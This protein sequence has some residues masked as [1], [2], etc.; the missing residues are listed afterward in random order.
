MNLYCNFVIFSKSVKKYWPEK[1]RAAKFGPLTVRCVEEDKS[2]PDV[3]IRV[4]Q[5]TH[6]HDQVS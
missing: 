2:V 6:A 3:T 4:F 5:I 1:G